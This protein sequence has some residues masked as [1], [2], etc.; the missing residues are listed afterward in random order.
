MPLMAS[1]SFTFFF[2]VDSQRATDHSQTPVWS[3]PKSSSS[4]VTQP[5]T[6]V[7]PRPA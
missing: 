5:V 1:Q 3:S 4:M 7:A 6:W 2:T